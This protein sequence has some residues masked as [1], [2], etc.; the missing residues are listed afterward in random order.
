VSG[1]YHSAVFAL[2]Q[3][4]PVVAF[5]NA[6]YYR[7][8]FAGL[9]DQYGDGLQLLEFDSCHTQLLPAIEKA[10]ESANRLRP[11]LLRLTQQL[12]QMSRAAYAALPEI[13]NAS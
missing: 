1:S 9:K 12:I 5:A 3:G 2:G 13:L 8:K 6:T 7:Q 4:I 10:W 11:E